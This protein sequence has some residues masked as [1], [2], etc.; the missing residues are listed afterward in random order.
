MET[1]TPTTVRHEI[2]MHPGEQREVELKNIGA[3]GHVWEV[4]TP[5][6]IEL[7]SK[8]IKPALHAFGGA[9]VTR[10]IFRA[11]KQ[12]DSEG[13]LSLVSPWDNKEKERHTVHFSIK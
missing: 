12:G 2:E 8:D 6:G 11:T 3:T 5:E 4:E 1:L 10:F 7:V 9:G 13:K